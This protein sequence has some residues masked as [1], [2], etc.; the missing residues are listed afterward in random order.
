MIIYANR[1]RDEC[2]QE[3]D[4]SQTIGQKKSQELDQKN[5]CFNVDECKKKLFSDKSIKFLSKSILQKL[6]PKIEDVFYS[7][8]EENYIEYIEKDII[9]FLVLIDKY[10]SENFIDLIFRYQLIFFF[11]INL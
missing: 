1:F 10:L 6:F 2:I 11:L 3:L 7:K 5:N 8:R 4:Q 9:G